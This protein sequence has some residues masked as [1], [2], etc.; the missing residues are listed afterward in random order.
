MNKKKLIIIS[1]LIVILCVII[2]V[3][4]HVTNTTKNEDKN[5]LVSNISTEEQS[6]ESN[7]NNGELVTENEEEV[8]NEEQNDKN[9]N[10]NNNNNNVNNSNKENTTNKKAE[11]QNANTN[12][13]PQQDNKPE[14]NK[15]HNNNNNGNNTTT[16]QK[17]EISVS[18]TISCKNALKYNVNVPANGYFLNTTTFKIKNGQSVFDVLSN[19]CKENGIRLDYEENYITGIGG[20]YE[21]DC[22]SQ[23]GWMYRVNGKLPLKA[24]TKYILKDGDN[25]EFY[26]VTSSNDMP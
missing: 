19:A 1:S 4:Q 21:K 8:S 5:S 16:T 23:S 25:I 3:F 6:G 18:L 12:D 13:F 2:G 20:L 10:E 7:E 26:Y 22:N 17:K 11:T 15:P 24:A 9:N 14:E